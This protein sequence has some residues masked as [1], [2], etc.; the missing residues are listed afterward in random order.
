MSGTEGLPVVLIHRLPAFNLLFKSR[1]HTHFTL[2]NP[3]H[4]SPDSIH[5]FLSRHAAS[6][7]ALVAVGPTPVN[8]QTLDLLS[9]LE[10]VV[11]S[12]AGIDH[13]DLCECRRRGVLVTSA[14]NAF[15]EDVADYSVALL[16]DVLRRVSAGNRFARAGLWPQ[17]GSYP[18]GSKL[19]GKRVGIV[20]LGSIGSEVAKRLAA[21]GCSIAYTSRKKKS[22]VS[23]PFYE[24]VRDLA[25]DSNVLIVCCALTDQTRRMISKDVMTALGKEGVIV[26]V[27][28]GALIDEKELVQ[29][30]LRG[31]IGGAG[32][33]V[34]ENEP[35][36]PEELF[37][38]DNVVLSPH[39]AALTPESFEA[40]QDVII[41]NLLAFFS[42][43]PLLSPV[44]LD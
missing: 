13:V 41:G 27:G 32:L 28:R 29:S 7:R 36:V 25:A 6:I 16:I 14:G 2:L 30:L 3:P 39:V 43:K 17:H 31:E 9:A 23:Y 4:D 33:D 19:G 11:C 21:F 10:I 42:N 35:Y 8:S 24:N 1:F 44:Q 22:A 12:S 37:A 34:Y 20:G 38:L 18:L 5:S 26:N 15:S 40:L